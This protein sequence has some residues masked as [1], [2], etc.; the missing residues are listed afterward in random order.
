MGKESNHV[1]AGLVLLVRA[2]CY[3]NIRNSLPP[4]GSV[5]LSPLPD[6][7]RMHEVRGDSLHCFRVEIPTY[8]NR[9]PPHLLCHL[10]QLWM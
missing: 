1:D 4:R 5:R 7:M 6:G 8:V 3:L 9:Q 10:A 2:V